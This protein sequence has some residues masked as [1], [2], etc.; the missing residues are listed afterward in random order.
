[1]KHFQT[2]S[3]QGLKSI[4]KLSDEDSVPLPS[5]CRLVKE[6]PDDQYG[7]SVKANLGTLPIIE[8]TDP[9]S[10]ADKSGVMSGMYVVGIN[11]TLL[12][13]FSTYKV[14]KLCSNVA[15]L[16]IFL[17]YAFYCLG[18]RKLD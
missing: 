8:S 9:G 5:W 11:Y 3:N 4:G 16:Y 7:F 2:D 1:M 17:Y 10:V 12:E 13:P 6:K 18:N 14:K 15:L